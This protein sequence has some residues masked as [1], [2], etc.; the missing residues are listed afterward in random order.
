MHKSKLQICVKILC[1]LS[2]KGPMKLTQIGHEVELDNSVLVGYLSFLYD[3][4]LVGEQNLSEDEKDYF[5]TERGL[6][7]LK[8]MV[9]LVREAQRVQ[10]L[11]FESISSVLS[12]VTFNSG[13]VEDEKPRWNFSKFIKEKRPKLKLSDFIKIEIE[14]E[15]ES[16]E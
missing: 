7:V 12:G 14:K 3:R 4:C 2:S 16:R 6:S 13:K 10:M 11:N 8:I 15:E 1:S 9:P 5:V